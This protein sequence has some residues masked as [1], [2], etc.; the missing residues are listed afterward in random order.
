VWFR[1]PRPLVTRPQIELLPLY[2]HPPA[3]ASPPSV[4]RRYPQ[5]SNAVP[6]R[7]LSRRY[8][9]RELVVCER[10]HQVFT[11]SIQCAPRTPGAPSSVD[12]AARP[13]GTPPLNRRSVAPSHFT[14]PRL[15]RRRELRTPRR[16]SARPR[17]Q[18]RRRF[19]ITRRGSLGTSSRCWA[20]GTLLE[21]D[22]PETLR[23][24]PLR[25]SFHVVFVQQHL[26]NRWS[27]LHHQSHHSR[28]ESLGDFS[29]RH[30]KLSVDGAALRVAKTARSQAQ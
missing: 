5:C 2:D 29:A 12:P 17:R 30:A 27:L 9:G 11:A 1:T 8:S 21:A 20:Q 3:R 16:P 4:R 25:P 26:P 7:I 19:G 13:G 22:S 18:P 15:L 6:L 28:R 10:R 23:A 24:T 14:E